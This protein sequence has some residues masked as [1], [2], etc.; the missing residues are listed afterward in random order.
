MRDRQEIVF[1]KEAGAGKER[2]PERP[3]AFLNARARQQIQGA[4][5]EAYPRGARETGMIRSYKDFWAG[6][7]FVVCGIAFFLLS[8]NY[9]IGSAR[10]M[11][12]AYFPTILSILL[13]VLG[14]LVLVRSFGGRREKLHGA[15]IRGLCLILLAVV[16]FA[17]LV[18]G[19]GL[20]LALVAMIG[21]SALASTRFHPVTAL[22]MMVALVA[23][24]IVVFSLA[25]RLPLQLFGPWIGG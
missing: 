7:M 4:R 9:N 10:H 8:Q 11:G 3:F 12:P 22:L 24:C 13:V 5:T 23:F 21:I 2:G 15:S 1:R 18:R 14:L 6:A 16:A 25:L 20:V 19:A 17:A